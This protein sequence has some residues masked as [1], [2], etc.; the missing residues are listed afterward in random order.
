MQFAFIVLSL[1]R[2]LFVFSTLLSHRIV[3]Q[4][5]FAVV[6]FSAPG[7][8]NSN[9]GFGPSGSNHSRPNGTQNFTGESPFGGHRHPG[10][11]TWAPGLD[12]DQG[13]GNATFMPGF[14]GDQ[15][16]GNGTRPGK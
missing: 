13:P 8:R 12:G 16:P 7:G 15:G 6:V 4:S 3:I 9:R 1:V 11:V 14:G 10:N 2:I 5:I